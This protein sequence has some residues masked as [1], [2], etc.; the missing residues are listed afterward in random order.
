MGNFATDTAVQPTGDGTFS[1]EIGAD[2]WVVAGP[3][4][5]YLAAIA[6]R[7]LEAGLEVGDRP[8]RSLTM[9]YMRAPQA[10]PATVEVVTERQGRSVTFARLRMLQDGRP[11]ATGLAVLARGGESMT[12]AAA[13]APDVPP[14]QA[15]AALADH[16][17][18]LP[19][20]RQ[21]EYRPAVEPAAGDEAV[22]GGWLRLRDGAQQL[23]SALL[24]ALCDCWFPAIFSAVAEP[25]AVPTLDLTIHFRATLPAP[26]GW[27]L[28]SFVTRTVG[29]GLLEEDAELFGE[30]GRLLAQS[31]QLALAR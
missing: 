12:L 14:P 23:D 2:W 27:A 1:C 3:N 7:A 30:D 8:L 13:G 16:E 6:V 24:A 28:G 20:V 4:G 5:G 26:A 19:F 31:R 25:L 9:H 18:A 15:I 21:F 22:A 17:Q 10:G 29:D 11:F